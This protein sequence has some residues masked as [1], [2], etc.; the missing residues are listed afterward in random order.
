[1]SSVSL[2]RVVEAGYGD[3]ARMGYRFRCRVE[4]RT[5]RT[6]FGFGAEVHEFRPVLEYCHLSAWGDFSL[7]EWTTAEQAIAKATIMLDAI[8][9]K[10]G[11]RENV[12]YI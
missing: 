11:D 3:Y 6:W 5:R 1:M 12:R 4:S 7:G 8:A 10:P 2:P 9:S